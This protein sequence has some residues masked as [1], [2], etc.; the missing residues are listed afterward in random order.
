MPVYAQVFGP[1][2]ALSPIGDPCP[3]LTHGSSA[4]T[5]PRSVQ[6]FC[7]SQ[8]WPRDRRT[9]RQTDR[10]YAT[11][12]AIVGAAYALHSGGCRVTGD[13]G[14]AS[15]RSMG[16]W[17][18][19][20]SRVLPAN[21]DVTQGDVATQERRRHRRAREKCRRHHHRQRHGQQRPLATTSGHLSVDG[22][23]SLAVPS[24]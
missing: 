7:G 24:L 18:G 22:A 23:T 14:A 16:A 1:T 5:A 8:A 19:R 21:G 12:E 9:D 17:F 6:P 3:H 13:G 20:S 11:R 15:S 2:S 10:P 4:Q